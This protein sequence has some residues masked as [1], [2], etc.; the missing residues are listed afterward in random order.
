VFERCH[1]DVCPDDEGGVD[2]ESDHGSGLLCW[3][4]ASAAVTGIPVRGAV[5]RIHD[6]NTHERAKSCRDRILVS[7]PR[8]LHSEKRKAPGFV[9]RGL[10]IESTVDRSGAVGVEHCDPDVSPDDEGGVNN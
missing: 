2:E 5:E 6:I 10:A 3:V 7:L 8:L 4:F 1:P 9:R